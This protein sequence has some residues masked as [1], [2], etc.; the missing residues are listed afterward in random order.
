MNIDKFLAE[1]TIGKQSELV[2]STTDILSKD[3]ECYLGLKGMSEKEGL[4]SF[5]AEHEITK[6]DSTFGHDRERPVANIGFSEKENKWYGW[7][8]RAIFGFTIG[9][10]VKFGDCAFIASNKEEYEKS[11]LKFW[12]GEDE[13][14]ISNGH[15]ENKTE[16]GFTV[17]ADYSNDVPNESLRG[18]KYTHRCEYPEKY[19]KG[20]WTAETIDDAK[21][22]AIDFANSVA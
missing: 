18:T 6:F 10:E 8:H 22:M 11:S 12:A 7:S 4:F 13:E 3:T 17:T 21:Q 16:E 5:F 9:S 20:E 1:Y 19:G 2:S 15:I 14:Y